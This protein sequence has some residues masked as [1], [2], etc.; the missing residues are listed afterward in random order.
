MA[1]LHAECPLNSQY[2]SIIS[3]TDHRNGLC[4][5][6]LCTCK[7]HICP[8]SLSKEPYP[9]SMYSSQYT[10]N[11]TNYKFSKPLICKPFNQPTSSQPVNF[12]TTS[13]EFYRPVFSPASLT[14]PNQLK[15]PLPETKFL[16][17]T[18]Y[19]SNYAN[20]GTGGVYYVTQQH[21]K[22][23]S[24]DIQLHSKSN[25]Q[26]QY[27]EID[28][29]ELLKPKKLGREVALVQKSMGLKVNNAPI[30]K[31]SM[32]R[33]DFPDYSKKG[34]TTREQKPYEKI[35]KLKSTNYHYLT[36]AQTDFIGHPFQVDH[37]NIRRQ[38][39]RN[40]KLL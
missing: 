20:W 29:E 24:N 6:P 18:S 1:N 14:L 13:D 27:I 34:Y 39:E 19:A 38:H 11:F 30:L 17:K 8:S 7:K 37:R 9:K 10:E 2:S 21:L 26:D 33:R 4:L 5:C 28:K 16:G 31:E 22:H 23:T 32:S 3:E 40:L 36:M 12:Q 25:Y 35:P 15:S